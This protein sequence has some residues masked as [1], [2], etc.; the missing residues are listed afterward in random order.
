M[1]K[2][3]LKME[4]LLEE[5]S[6]SQ[7]NTA[8]KGN[9]YQNFIF[10]NVKYSQALEF[11]KANYTILSHLCKISL[12]Y[13]CH[14]ILFNYCVPS[15]KCC[16]SDVVSLVTVEE[17]ACTPLKTHVNGTRIAHQARNKNGWFTLLNLI[18]RCYNNCSSWYSVKEN[19]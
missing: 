19:W 13:F 11:T 4:Q 15:N 14:Q 5:K 8:S 7:R 3:M 9:F 12:I 16:H 6:G 1:K 18:W 2:K 17:P 10:Y